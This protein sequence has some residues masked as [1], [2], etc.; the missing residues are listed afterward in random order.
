MPITFTSMISS[1]SSSDARSSSTAS[2]RVIP[3]AA[4]KRAAA[5]CPRVGPAVKGP[6]APSATHQVSASNRST[7][8][9]FCLSTA[10]IKPLI[11]TVMARTSAVATAAMTNRRCRNTRSR[12]VIRHT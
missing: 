7:A 11:S 3:G 12:H 8:R 6:L 9:A 4:A 1:V 5:S 2:A 10:T